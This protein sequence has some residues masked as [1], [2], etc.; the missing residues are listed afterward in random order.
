MRHLLIGALV[1]GW[2]CVPAAA[3]ESAPVIPKF[4]E[5]TKAAGLDHTFAGEWEF[6]V[7]GGAA[8]FD[9]DDD[10]FPDLLMS[11]GVNKAK[12]YR[13]ASLRGGAIKFSAQES[14]LELDMVSGAYPLDVDGDGK[15][16]LVLLRVGE[17][18]VMR[19]LGG[20]RF[21]RA[22]EAWGFAGGDLWWTSLAATWE[23]GADWPTIAVGSYIDRKEEISP[24]GSCTDNW[25]L[26]PAARERKFAAPVV[27]KPSFC[28]LSMLF[29][30]WNRSGTPSLRVSND[31]EYYEG[32]QEQMWKVEPG[33]EPSL[34]SAAEGWRN[35]RIWGMGIAGYDLN[36]DGYP[37]YFLTSMADNKLQS[38]A[39]TPEDGSQPKPTYADIAFAK[40]VTAHRPYMGDDSKPS[41]AWHTEFQDVNND[42]Q[43]DLFVV[44]GNVW[45]MPDFA[46]KDPNNLLIQRADGKFVEAGD[47]AGVASIAQGRGGA[48]VDLN[49]DGL[50][51]LL[52]VNRNE[53]S[54]LWRNITADAGRWLQLRLAQPG[55][56]RDAVGAW[57][58]V[59]CGEHV[60]RREVTV[61]GGHAGG[62]AGWH[63]FGVADLAATELRVIWPD[64]TAAAWQKVPTDAFYLVER[65]KSPAAWTPN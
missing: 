11:G 35:L 54:E 1:A 57:I 37:E 40:G 51:D 41:T 38:L 34:Y 24:W 19:G 36:F 63:H 55:P 6:M 49:L 29:T 56:N 16:D 26:R 53:P 32:G 59:K 28:P 3:Q 48:A 44:K 25:L 64:G 18:V 4:A 17:N 21:E 47:K 2:L 50:I 65:D 42:G 15:T 23:H 10:G 39:A 31:R 62:H 60:M 8:T 20:C 58:E 52:V 43:V 27:L 7:G 33:K 5:E 9:C 22:N 45:E 30:D 13:N 61:G 14:G 46:A 12:F